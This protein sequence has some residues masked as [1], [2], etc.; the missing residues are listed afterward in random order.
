VD[1]GQ[2]NVFE[3]CFV[4]AY[5]SAHLHPAYVRRMPAPERWRWVERVKLQL[6]AEEKAAQ[7]D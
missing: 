6:D 5:S 1:G 2:L 3:D 4:L 7:G